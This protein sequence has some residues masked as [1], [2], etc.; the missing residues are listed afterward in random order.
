M[1]NNPTS[2]TNTAASSNQQQSSYNA[3][4]FIIFTTNNGGSQL[5]PEVTDYTDINMVVP[6][7]TTG[8]DNGNITLRR[9]TY[10]GNP[11]ALRSS[12]GTID[13]SSVLLFRFSG[14]QTASLIIPDVTQS[15]PF[16]ATFGWA[17]IPQSPYTQYLIDQTYPTVAAIF[18]S[19]DIPGLFVIILSNSSG[20]KYC[21]VFDEDVF[22]NSKKK[23][24][25]E[26]NAFENKKEEK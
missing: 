23:E 14:D 22:T 15:N 12:G 8:N 24:K 13:P 6:A 4:E 17:T 25:E 11:V 7:F 21:L 1:N 5:Q 20:F 19:N 26:N 9:Q 18:Q 3:S 10:S 2:T 16:V